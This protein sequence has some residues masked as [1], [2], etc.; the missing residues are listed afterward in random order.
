MN[1]YLPEEDALYNKD[2]E[3]YLTALNTALLRPME[4]IFNEV[5]FKKDFLWIQELITLY[6][7]I[8]KEN[9]SLLDECDFI[10]EFTADMTR[11]EFHTLCRYIGKK[12]Q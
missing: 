1:T 3:T 10:N 12:D 9:G 2:R 4:E 6:E 5:D 8:L 7:R 11:I